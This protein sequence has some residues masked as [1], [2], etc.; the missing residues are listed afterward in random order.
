MTNARLAGQVGNGLQLFVGYG[1]EPTATQVVVDGQEI[2]LSSS[3][4]AG[5]FSDVQSAPPFVVVTTAAVS[6]AEGAAAPL[7]PPTALHVE[8]E[9]H[10]I[11]VSCKRPAGRSWSVQL[12]PR[13]VVAATTGRLLFSP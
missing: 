3:E 9:K 5:M 8:V 13:L 4:S 1:T 7:Q 2:P 12:T 10:E 6:S 11:P